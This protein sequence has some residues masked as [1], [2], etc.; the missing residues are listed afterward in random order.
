MEWLF[1][2]FP[3]AHF[4]PSLAMVVWEVEGVS[5]TLMQWLEPKKKKM[6]TQL[7]SVLFYIYTITIQF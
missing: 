3:Q 5:N 1:S 7:K 4:Q 6:K 2:F